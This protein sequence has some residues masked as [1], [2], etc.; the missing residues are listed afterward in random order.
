MSKSEA[1]P[2]IEKIVA[3]LPTA[4]CRKVMRAALLTP[5]SQSRW[6][7]NMCLWGEP[8]IAKSA[9]IEA[10]AAEL[11]LPCAVLSPGERGE[12]AFG[13]IPVPK[14]VNGIDVISYPAPEWVA[15]MK[16]GGIVFVD[17][18]TTAPPAI[19]PALLGLAHA[20][21]I[22]GVVLGPRVRVIS[23][24]NP[25]ELAA[26]GYDLPPPEANRF[27]HIDFAPPSVDD[28]TAFMLS[29]AT[30]NGGH[31]DMTFDIKAEEARILAAWG[32]PW[33]IARGV[34]TAFLRARPT[35]KN[36][37]PKAGDP[38]GS[39]GW[40][41]DRSW[42]AATR[43]L[44]SAAV[45]GLTDTETEAFVAA[46]IGEGVAG[47][48]FAFKAKQDLPN[49]AD[50][51]DGRVRFVHSSSRLDRTYAVLQACT[52][53]VT[54]KEAQRRDERAIAL[55]S[56][57]LEPLVLAKA[58]LDVLVPSVEA[59][60]AA[61]LQALKQANKTLAGIQTMLRIAGIKPKNS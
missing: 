23:A 33:A 55:W 56:E 29:S 44:A 20:R 24:A 14:N 26:G 5:I 4:S 18:L 7:L 21:R 39:R 19:Q 40:P 47:E 28:H 2:K 27:G 53:L 51:L 61:G 31:V 11:G 38:K 60:I 52:A 46:F 8:G 37:C 42:E 57:V 30:G 41:S 13:V 58:D 10:L 35:L 49:P 59:L 6:G 36:V 32:E 12:G 15:N 16:D 50:I 34:E 9:I 48:F 1:A 3:S 45:H 25:P 54:P 17:E 43:A 22:G